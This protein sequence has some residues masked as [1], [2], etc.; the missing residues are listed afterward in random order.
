VSENG[1]ILY[2]SDA[3]VVACGVT[4]EEIT[5]SVETAF[6]AK[7]LGRAGTSRKLTLAVGPEANFAGKGGVLLDEGCAAVKWYGY[8]GNND[9]R[10]LPDFSPLLILSSS[11][12]GLPLAVVDGRWITAV[13]TASITAAAASVLAKPDS[14]SVGFVACGTQA[15]AN[16]AALQARFK[17]E[18][19]VAYSRNR[20]T[21]ERF[22]AMAREL[23]LAA[24]VAAE[25][26][27]AV[28]GLDIVVTSVPKFSQ[29]TRF[30]DARQVA[31][32]TFV[33]MV[34]MGFGWDAGTLGAFETVV[35][36]DLEDGTRRSAETLNYE[37]E[38]SADLPELLAEPGRW[39]NE[40]SAR[41][42]L[43][44]AGSGIADVAAAAAVYRRALE[45]GAGQKL[46]R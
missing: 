25:P 28:E 43:V 26:R 42:A 34:D 41:S 14:R 31:A 9:R 5:R 27:V 46:A 22:A 6:R 33:S 39:A 15:E 17:L 45:R 20:E 2:L 11:E 7:A 8:V 10:G 35:T 40:G 19:I 3:D 23:G 24:E 29:P 1:A 36:D 37:G 18:R 30:L 21:A 13:R 38:F 16:L 4:P 32:G 12:T 44:F